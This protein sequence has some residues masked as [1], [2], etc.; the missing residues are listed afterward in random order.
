MKQRLLGAGWPF[1]PTGAGNALEVRKFE[2]W[3]G[4]QV[5]NA[6]VRQKTSEYLPMVHD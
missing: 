1:M 3:N 2:Y 4:F 6:T 5:S